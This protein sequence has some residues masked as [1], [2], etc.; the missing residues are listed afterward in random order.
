MWNPLIRQ[1][2][3][4]NNGLSTSSV[5]EVRGK[6]PSWAGTV[7]DPGTVV[8]IRKLMPRRGP[9]PAAGPGNPGGE[10]SDRIGVVP[11]GHRCLLTRLS[12][13]RIRK[14]LCTCP[15]R[16]NLPAPGVGGR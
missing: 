9:P 11:V 12:Q 14:H 10:I 6:D 13:A 4:F 7:R 16:G 5:G 8:D 1:N 15:S 3:N 2:L